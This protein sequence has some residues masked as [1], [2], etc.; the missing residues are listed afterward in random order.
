MYRRAMWTLK[1]RNIVILKYQ[2]MIMRFYPV[3]TDQGNIYAHIG[4]R[5]D[6]P[7]LKRRT[8]KK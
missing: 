5:D 6:K 8:V 4:M 7:H 1:Y 2:R 3:I